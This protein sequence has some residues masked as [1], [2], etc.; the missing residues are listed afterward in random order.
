MSL[1]KDTMTP[2]EIETMSFRARNKKA[3]EVY[4]ILKR[5][6]DISLVSTFG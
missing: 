5:F 4:D 6:Q 1:W 2:E 3:E